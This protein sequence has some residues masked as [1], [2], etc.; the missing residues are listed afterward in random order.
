MVCSLSSGETVHYADKRNT[1]EAWIEFGIASISDVLCKWAS[2]ACFLRHIA[3]ETR[4]LLIRN[5]AIA[6][7]FRANNQD[8][9]FII[10]LHIQVSN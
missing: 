5:D 1:Q 6:N 8:L 3:A 7:E 9:Q 2:Y 10:E 4:D